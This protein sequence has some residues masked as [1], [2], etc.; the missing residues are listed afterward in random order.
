MC[1]RNS[2]AAS[3]DGLVSALERAG[4]GRAGKTSH[5]A[6]AKRGTSARQDCIASVTHATRDI[7]RDRPL[8]PARIGTQRHAAPPRGEIQARRVALRRRHVTCA[9]LQSGAREQGCGASGVSLHARGPHPRPRRPRA[10]DGTQGDEGA[11]DAKS[12]PAR[13]S[14]RA[15]IWVWI[16]RTVGDRPVALP[17]CSC[18][19]LGRAG[20][21]RDASCPPPFPASSC[22]KRGM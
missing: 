1:A 3:Q 17:R 9:H 18:L 13:A 5:I 4:A 22:A 19:R 15:P 7:S 2:R 21:A 8:V 14:R 11:G 12:K 16:L 20:G 6:L 10:V